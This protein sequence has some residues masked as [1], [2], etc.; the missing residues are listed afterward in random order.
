MI[1]GSTVEL[2]GF[3]KSVTTATIGAFAREV[4]PHFP[5]LRG[6]AVIRTWAGLR[7]ATPDHAPIIQLLDEPE[8]YCLAVG[9]SRR[10]IC[11]AG[12]TGRLVA[13]LLTGKP[14]FLPLGRFRLDRFPPEPAGAGGRG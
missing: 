2:A 10:G 11:Y 3:D 9:H 8:G 1:V 6:L 5:R 12:G 7:P 14:P 4:L 13:E